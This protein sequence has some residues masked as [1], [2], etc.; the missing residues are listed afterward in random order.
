LYQRKK[1]KAESSQLILLKP[2]EN[3]ELLITQ[4]TTDIMACCQN[5]L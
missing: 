4:N 5:I 3:I 2:M 1:T